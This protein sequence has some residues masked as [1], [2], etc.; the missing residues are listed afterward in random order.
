[1]DKTHFWFLG[2]PQLDFPAQVISR[3]KLSPKRPNTAGRSKE[4][5]VTG[6]TEVQPPYILGN[7]SES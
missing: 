2:K 5:L 3:Q 1:L 7:F 4:V 6:T